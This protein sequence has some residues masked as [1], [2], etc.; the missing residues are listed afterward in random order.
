MSG[1]YGYLSGDGYIC[2]AMYVTFS[3]RN[4]AICDVEV[5]VVFVRSLRLG[6][7]VRLK[8]LNNVMK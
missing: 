4:V 5:L 2:L 6:E 3:E 7:I 1:R 8:I